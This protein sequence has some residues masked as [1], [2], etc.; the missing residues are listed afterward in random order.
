MIRT[1]IWEEN[2]HPVDQ[3]VLL[4]TLS[5]M[6]DRA[7]R[8]G[9]DAD[10]IEDGRPEWEA[11]FLKGMQPLTHPDVFRFFHKRFPGA[12]LEYRTKIPEDL[13]TQLQGKNMELTETAQKELHPEIDRIVT[14]EIEKA[15]THWTENRYVDFQF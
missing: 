8:P 7:G 3:P 5:R 13:E 1:V 4:K 6:R 15:E 14:Q 12:Y 11:L 2:E 9:E 10:A